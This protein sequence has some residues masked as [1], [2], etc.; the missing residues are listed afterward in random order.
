VSAP[1]ST[2]ASRST[3]S[4][5]RSISETMPATAAGEP[6]DPESL[7]P[8]GDPEEVARL[9]CLRLLDRRAYTRTE[10]E[11]ALRRKGVPDDAAERVLDRFSELRLVDDAALAT[12]YALAQHRD[13]GLAGRAVAL[14]LR[15]RGVADDTVRAAVG[16]ID[17]DS[18][19]AAARGLVERRLRSLAG[20]DPVVQARRL[21]GL[22]ARKGYAPGLAHDVVRAALRAAADDADIGLGGPD[23]LDGLPD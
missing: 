21:V 4:R 6:D 20:L 9:V 12:G 2:R 17:R 8:P 22:L 10:L 16:P 3:W 19:A 13:R 1:A 15:Q 18:E 23:S 14:K 5:R 7:G 11:T